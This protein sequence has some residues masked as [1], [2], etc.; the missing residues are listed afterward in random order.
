MKVVFEGDDPINFHCL[1]MLV[2]GFRVRL[3]P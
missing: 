3:K 2:K 1:F